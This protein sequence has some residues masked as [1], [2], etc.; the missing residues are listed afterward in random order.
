M[1]ALGFAADQQD[2]RRKSRREQRV[3]SL[4]RLDWR[5]HLAF[6]R[7]LLIIYEYMSGK[8]CDHRITFI[9]NMKR[10]FNCKQDK[11]YKENIKFT[12][13][14]LGNGRGCHLSHAVLKRNRKK[15]VILTLPLKSLLVLFFSLLNIS[16]IWEGCRLKDS[17]PMASLYLFILCILFFKDVI[18]SKK[19]F[20][21]GHALFA[22]RALVGSNYTF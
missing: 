17:L 13:C 20:A 14:L 15:N 19:Q 8:A 7:G 12:L 16:L 9:C 10:S 4:G 2:Q 3:T 11:N 21:A 6:W 18:Y 22:N 1:C 5:P